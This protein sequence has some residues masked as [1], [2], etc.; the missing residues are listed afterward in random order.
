MKA[1]IAIAALLAL[2][3]PG[4]ADILILRDGTELH[5]TFISG[6]RDKI[7]FE[8][9]NGVRTTFN[10]DRVQSVEIQKEPGPYAGYFGPAGEYSGDQGYYGGNVSTD[11]YDG[12]YGGN[13]KT[14]EYGG[15]S[16]RVVPAGTDIVVRTDERIKGGEKL[17]GKVFPAQVI[18]PVLDAAG[19]VVIPQGATA[20]LVVRSGGTLG[21]PG[22]MLDIESIRIDGH[23]Y[24]VSSGATGAAVGLITGEAGGA[25]V[26]VLTQGKKIDVPA[27]TELRFPV[28]RPLELVPTNR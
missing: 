13:V 22:L 10:R 11:E 28:A 1:F 12:Y 4:W 9:D 20:E 6:S 21:S 3:S 5:G 14:D 27:E 19:N 2:T 15:Y 18:R 7:V 24:L 8:Q 17:V 25:G 23:R 16:A 26:Q